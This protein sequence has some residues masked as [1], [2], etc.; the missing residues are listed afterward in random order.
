MTNRAQNHPPIPPRAVT[1][2]N[3]PPSNELAATQ[4]AIV[5]ELRA[6][7]SFSTAHKEGGTTIRFDG[8]DY[9]RED[10]G[11][12]PTVTRHA[13][14]A[15]LLAFLRRFF[16]HEV[17]REAGP[18]VSEAQAWRLIRRRLER[19]R[20]R[21]TAAA[22]GRLGPGA[23]VAA[24]LGIVVLVFVAIGGVAWWHEA[25]QRM[26]A[27]PRPSIPPAPQLP[28]SALQDRTILSGPTT[29]R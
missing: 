7:A 27:P 10:F 26:S 11:E 22:F 12:S 20:G 19:P 1:R 16:E 9:V 8:R 3:G 2:D 6:G 4:R 24:V 18:G 5:A 25:R 29:S 21:A 14:D 28:R 15:E 13:T 17:T 23:R